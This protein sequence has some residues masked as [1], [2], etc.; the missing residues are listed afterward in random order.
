[1]TKINI[2]KRIKEYRS[3]KSVTQEQ[4]GA[5]IGVS[6]QAISKWEREECYPDITFLPMLADILSCSV[7]DFFE[8]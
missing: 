8:N 5:L 1:M 6:A 4:F 2:A 3:I 7:N